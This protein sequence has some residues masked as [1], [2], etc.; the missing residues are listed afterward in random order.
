M[1]NLVLENKTGFT[2]L[3]PFIIYELNGNVFYSSDF[4]NKIEQDK[5]LNFNLPAGRYTYEGTFIKLD[6][7]IKFKV[8]TLPIFER[9][10]PKKKYKIIFGDNPNKCSIF[11]STGIILFDQVFKNA[12]LYVKY[13][14]YF[15]ELGHHYYKT[16]KYAD[17]YAVKKML[18]YGFNPSQIGRVSIFGLSSESMERKNFIIKK[19]TK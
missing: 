3:V 4:V 1:K 17:L 14:I 18:D 10:L 5:R 13:G 19:V 16:E 15:H 8:I 9:N 11:Y 6:N 7:P 2:T 12:P